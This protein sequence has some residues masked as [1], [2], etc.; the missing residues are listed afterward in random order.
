MIINVF[1]G[2]HN[3]ILR[4][5][6]KSYS[7]PLLFIIFINDIAIHIKNV[8]NT[9]YADD[10]T[11]FLEGKILNYSTVA[12]SRGRYGSGCPMRKPGNMHYPYKNIKYGE[13]LKSK[14][15][16]MNEEVVE[17]DMKKGY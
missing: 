1:I 10:T 8:K 16:R 7:V 4:I 9:I 15:K 3:K 2:V 12:Q 11:F 13:I 17:S 5:L 14:E 6:N